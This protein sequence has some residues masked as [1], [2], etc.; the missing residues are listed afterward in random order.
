MELEEMMTQLYEMKVEYRAKQKAFKDTNKHLLESIKCLEN[1]VTDEVI[2]RGK[3]V[4]VAGIKA[5][6]KPAVIIKIKR[7]ENE[8]EE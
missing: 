3:T 1:L 6:Y 8:R 5:E 4:K 2:K 7:D